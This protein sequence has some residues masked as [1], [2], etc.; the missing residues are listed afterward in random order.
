LKKIECGARDLDVDIILSSLAEDSVVLIPN[1]AGDDIDS[2]IV[3][4][5]E[6]LGLRGSLELQAG[7]AGFLGHRSNI[8]K[9]FMTVNNRGDYQFIPPHSE[10]DSFIGMELAAFFCYENSTDGGETLLMNVDG[11]GQAWNSLREK[12]S[13]GKLGSRSLSPGERSRARAL[14]RLN[15]P[16]DLLQ[17]DDQILEEQKSAIPGLMV[18]DVLAKPT[19]VRSRILNRELYAYW[20]SI[21]SIDSHSANQYECLLRQS[22][23]LKNPPDHLRIAHLDSAAPR[24]IWNSGVNYTE[25][26]KCRITRKLVPGDLIIFNNLTWTHAANNWSPGSGVRKM[27]AAFA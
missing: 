9:Y 8:G 23:L 15:L 27:V 21:A 22:A 5:A 4:V 19:K 3:T 25:I 17:S 1:V 13:R 14:Y 20:D 24:R 16:D 18:V 26:F 7:F 10:G 6:R 12:K 11:A 2:M